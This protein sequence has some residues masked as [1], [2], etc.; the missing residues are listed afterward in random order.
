MPWNKIVVWMGLAYKAPAALP[1]VMPMIGRLV[2]IRLL[3]KLLA[4]VCVGIQ[5]CPVE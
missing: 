3:I 2:E 5:A 1:V 4:D